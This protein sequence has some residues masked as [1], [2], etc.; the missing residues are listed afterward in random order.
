MYLLLEQSRHGAGFTGVTS[1]MVDKI[2]AH[3]ATLEQNHLTL[4]DHLGSQVRGLENEFEVRGRETER[5]RE[6]ERDRE[7]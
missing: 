5:K 6:R 3:L 1:A 2:E 4:E 7:R